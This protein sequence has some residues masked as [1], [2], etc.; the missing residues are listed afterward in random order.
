MK[1]LNCFHLIIVCVIGGLLVGCNPPN[2]NDIVGSYKRV[3]QTVTETLNIKPDGKFQQI[4]KYADGRNW[5]IEDS[6][7]LTERVVRLDKC[8]QT[9]DFEKSAIIDPPKLVYMDSLLWDGG[10]LFTSELDKHPF[11]KT[12]NNNDSRPQSLAVVRVRLRGE[13][14]GGCFSQPRRPKDNY[15]YCAGSWH[16]LRS[17]LDSLSLSR[18]GKSSGELVSVMI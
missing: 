12:K 3:D 13:R 4:V 11:Q 16:S 14:G 7:S 8:Y 9:Y 10:L 1:T 15:G 2:K 6:W 17:L 5:I 18:H